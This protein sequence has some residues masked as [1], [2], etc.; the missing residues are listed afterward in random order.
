MAL[1]IGEKIGAFLGFIPG[2][3]TFTGLIKAFIYFKKSRQEKVDSAQMEQTAQKTAEQAKKKLID[4]KP[5]CK[6]CYQKLWKASLI[7]MIPG[8]NIISAAYSSTILHRLS[9]LREVNTDLNQRQQY[10]F[11]KFGIEPYKSLSKNDPFPTAEKN[12]LLSE[13]LVLIDSLDL[14]ED[15]KREIA[16]ETVGFVIGTKETNPNFITEVLINSKIGELETRIH[17]LKVERGKAPDQN[18]QDSRTE[19]LLLDDGTE[20]EIEGRWPPLVDSFERDE[21]LANEQRKAQDKL[22]DLFGALKKIE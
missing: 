9:Q 20:I 19:K 14:D 1:T 4:I 2:V 15:A 21:I 8:I 6:A 10:I 13:V 3:S 5:G 18:W 11:E 22:K 12:Q 7:E 16:N 17:N